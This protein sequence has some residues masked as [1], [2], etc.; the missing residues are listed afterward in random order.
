MAYIVIK[1]IKGRQYQYLQ[2]TYRQGGKVRTETVYL[3]P[4]NGGGR[5]RGLLRRVGDFVRANL[6]P[7]HGLPD[8]E[9]MLR[10]YNDRVER[11]RR[12]RDKLLSELHDRYGLRVPPGSFCAITKL[13]E[14]EAD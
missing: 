2:R 12:E 13:S 5:R 1:T 8:E 7:R 14:H 4:V 10:Q 3:G 9:T 6:T 11:E